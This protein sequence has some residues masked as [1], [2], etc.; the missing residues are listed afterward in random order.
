VYQICESKLSRVLLCTSK[1][2]RGCGEEIMTVVKIAY[3]WRG[4]REASILRDLSWNEGVVR[5]MGCVS[6]P[7]RDRV[8]IVMEVYPLDMFQMIKERG[9]MDRPTAH[10]FF[11]RMCRTMSLCH[12]SGFIHRDIKPE[13]LLI[14]DDGDMVVADW[15][16]GGRWSPLRMRN[17][18]LGSRDYVADE[19]LSNRYYV[20]PEV[21]I[22]S[23]GAVLHSMLSGCVMYRIAGND[24]GGMTGRVP[25]ISRHVEDCDRELISMMTLP[26]PLKRATMYDIMSFLSSRVY[27]TPTMRSPRMMVAMGCE[28]GGNEV[29]EEEETMKE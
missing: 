9:R 16:F 7:E 29:K 6:D 1:G 23:M 3:G 25:S 5:M 27:F 17:T 2:V 8:A 18:P 26:D 20:G 22:F 14:D 19:I 28:E 10:R 11:F 21:D 12:S 4:T 15:G 13:N 24:A